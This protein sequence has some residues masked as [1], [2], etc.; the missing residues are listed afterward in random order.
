[1]ALIPGT[2]VASR[3]VPFDTLDTFAT[4]DATYGRDGYRSV[5]D[6]TE[7]DSITE[8]RQKV[9]MLVYVQSE[10]KIYKLTVIG[11]PATYEELA[12][13]GGTVSISGG[14]GISVV[15]SP[16]NTFTISLDNA[17]L[18]YSIHGRVSLNVGQQTY[19]IEHDPVVFSAPVLSLSTPSSADDLFIQGVY[20]VSETGFDVVLSTIPLITGY[21]LNYINGQL[22]TTDNNNITRTEVVNISSNLQSQIDSINIVAGS[23]VTIYE[24]PDNTWTISAAVS[25]GSTD[26]NTLANLQGG[27]TNQYYHLTAAQASG[28]ISDAEVAAISGHLQAQIDAI[29]PVDTTVVLGGSGIAVIESPNDTFTVSVSGNYATPS[30]LTAYTLRTE[31]SAVSGYLN[32]KINSINIVAGSNITVYENPDNT[33]TISAAVSG[34]GTDHN[35]LANLQG[36]TTNQYYHLT[37]AQINSY[38][39]DTEV[40]AVSGNLQAQINAI[41]PVD[42]TVVLGGTGISVVESPN[43]TFTVSVSGSYATVAQVGSLTGSLQTQINT[44]PLSSYTLRTETS[45]VSGY[46]NNRIDSVGSAAGATGEL[47]FSDGSGGFLSTADMKYDGIELDI[48]CDTHLTN[49]VYIYSSI[50]LNTLFADESEPITVDGHQNIVQV[51]ATG[52]TLNLPSI[53]DLY[54]GLII[55]IINNSA[56]NCNIVPA[57]P[58]TIDG[59]SS[60]TL[61]SGK[62]IQIVS[63]DQFTGWIVIKYFSTS[64]LIP[65][66]LRTETAAI[67]GYLQG[68]INAI[69]SVDTTRVLGGSGISVIESPNDTFTVS[70]SGDYV[71]NTVLSNFVNISGDSITGQL[72]ITDDTQS[73]SLSAAAM[74]IS[75]GLS[76][77]KNTL[78]GGNAVITDKV[79]PVLTQAQLQISKSS[80][81]ITGV[82][83]A[84]SI[85]LTDSAII[86]GSGM[87]IDWT[88]G[89]SNTTAGYICGKSEGT[90]YLS[91]SL[92]S[93]VQSNSN[94]G[95][96]SSITLSVPTSANDNDLLIVMIAKQLGDPEVIITPPIGWTLL[97]GSPQS[98]TGFQWA[99]GHYIYYKL[100]NSE[101]A[102]YTWNFDTSTYS[103]GIMS[104]YRNVNQTNPIG[105]INYYINNSWDAAIP[106]PQINVLTPNSFI[107][108]TCTTRGSFD[109]LISGPS[110]PY[111]RRDTFT[112]ECCYFDSNSLVPTGVNSPGTFTWPATLGVS[113]TFSIN[114]VDVLESTPF[115]VSIGTRTPNND[116][117]DS[118]VIKGDG[119]ILIPNDLIVEKDIFC[120]INDGSLL[121][122]DS[123]GKIIGSNSQPPDI[124]RTEIESI[125]A[126]LQSQVDS[127]N[128]IGST[129]I[130][131]NESPI[132][133]WTLSLTGQ[134]PIP[135]TLDDLSNVVLTNPIENQ[136]LKYNGVNWVN[137]SPTS[138][139][140]ASV[141]DDLLDVSFLTT[142]SS[143]QVLTYKNL[144]WENSYIQKTIPFSIVSSTTITSGT[145]DT[146]FISP[147]SGEIVEWAITC[148]PS[149]NITMDVLKDY[150]T[151]PTTSIISS[152]YPNVSGK[153][154]H[155]TNLS[156]WNTNINKN[157]VIKINVSEN[158]NAKVIVFQLTC[159]TRN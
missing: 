97:P 9:G 124:F 94:Q 133:T 35:T 10:D 99:Y 53:I 30:E 154:S 100:A 21:S 152:N 146:M 129:G 81:N 109:T 131:I 63:N 62:S 11:F 130:S 50:S 145:K 86:S 107:V 48:Q 55:T 23:N 93:F 90:Q 24:N 33:W 157:D 84:I 125:S 60:Y 151:E 134:Q 102:S 43:D 37:A 117:Q 7:R 118:L 116:I 115:G 72:I 8:Q 70:V 79:D 78:I 74:V 110:Y 1:M 127:F 44:I 57:G 91:S 6:I 19:H 71:S 17:N 103:F 3:I 4:H 135:E 156:G 155:S 38:I 22:A 140:G 5:A 65:Y 58:Q 101:P 52:V 77:N 32:N 113:F 61:S 148:S 144:S 136:V 40:A 26:H 20:N 54:D 85:S 66:T 149:S 42:T 95:Y 159:N 15:E 108:T 122:T 29:S 39:S 46:L 121:T 45:A 88:T 73:T 28:Y 34:G 12:I 89:N 143:G 56:G 114:P 2:N 16:A 138:G 41:S 14:Q 104:A 59:Q 96:A 123:N 141:L 120:S 67:S 128:I 153:I 106:A 139:G 64:D 112:V 137:G 75:G 31:T 105:A 98:P 126:G 51:N 69:S 147:F 82:V 36:G 25:G 80:N 87:S 158:T 83:P 132:N 47:Q 68:Q 119:T 92:I 18:N 27:I 13:S 76:I 49:P 150:D 111:V 142:P